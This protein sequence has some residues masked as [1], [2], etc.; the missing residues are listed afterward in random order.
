MTAIMRQLL[1]FA[2][3]GQARKQPVELSG[4]IK[5]TLDL[6]A[7]TARNQGIDLHWEAV[8]G[9]LT[10]N[11]D[12]GQLQQVLLNLAMNGIQS[13]PE[14]GRLSLQLKKDCVSSPPEGRAAE[15]GSWCC[16]RVE[17]QGVGIAPENL[18]HIF[19]PFYTTKDVGRGTGLGLSIAYGIAEEHGGWIEVVS[20]PFEGSCFI[21]FLPQ[22]TRGENG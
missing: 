2:R 1:D 15:N 5:G 20:T 16:I 12:P 8:E 3:R 6:L 10:V 7:P 9:S 14:G 13:M 19:D 21:V 18:S 17:D 22:A 4:L 11:A